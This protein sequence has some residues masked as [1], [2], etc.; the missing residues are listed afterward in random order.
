MGFFRKRFGISDQSSTTARMALPLSTVAAVIALRIAQGISHDKF[1]EMFGEVDYAPGWS[2]NDA[3]AV[4]YSLGNLA[5]VNVV[6]SRY[7]SSPERANKLIDLVRPQLLGLWNTSE[8]TRDRLLLVV[9]ETE[10]QALRSFNVC[11]N[12]SEL[13]TFFSRYASRIVGSPVSFSSRSNLEE[14]LMGTEN[15][16]TNPIKNTALSM[17]FIETCVAINKYLEDIQINWS[18]I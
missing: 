7:G 15:V 14:I 17:I 12:G 11:T 5:L 2:A 3:L 4:W 6:W 8:A 10:E 18:V 16:G 1:Y 13:G 9:Q